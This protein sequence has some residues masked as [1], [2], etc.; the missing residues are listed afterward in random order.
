MTKLE[1]LR[2]CKTLGDFAS[3]IGYKPKSLSFILYKIPQQNKYNEFSIPKRNGDPRKIKSPIDELKL[4]QKHLANLLNECYGEINKNTYSLSHGFRKKH[5]ILSNASK[6]TNKR[7]VFNLD[8]EDFFPSINFGRVRGFLIKNKHFNL[9]E[10]VATV[11]AQ[12]A[13]H[14][15][16]LPQGSPCS[17]IIS[18]LIGHLL[19]IRMVNLAKKTKCTYSRYADD[20]TFSTNNK[21]FPEKIALMKNKNEW[22]IGQYLRKEITKLGFKVN[23]NKTSI[24]YKISRQTATGL[25]VNKKPNIKREYYKQARAMSYELFKT[26]NFYYGNKGQRIIGTLNQLVGTVNFIYKIKRQHDTDKTSK[27][28]F[29]PTAIT[30]L[31]RQLLFYK[32]FFANDKPLIICEGKTDIIYL[33]CA[34]SQLKN[35]NIDLDL[36]FLNMTKN[37]KD[38]LA[39]SQGVSGLVS[40]IEMY[41]YHMKIFKGKGKKNPVIILADNDSASK[42]I[43][44]KIKAVSR[45]FYN[46]VDNLY[47]TFV[48]D[49]K[50]KVIED[51]FYKPTLNIK[52]KGKKF[53]G[54]DKIDS[55]KE[56]GK[57]VFAEQVVKENQNTIN[58]KRFRYM[59]N[60]V[61]S[62]IMHHKSK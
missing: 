23:K 26:N 52:I 55:N 12:I 33:K 7:Y 32:Y 53:N 10:K 38:V 35:P 15:N 62:I 8:L 29:H 61:N 44:N 14:E 16:E 57:I 31:Y 45:P 30:K 3:L 22:V 42:D 37:F 25:V 21:D 1:S 48:S 27:R 5:S 4:V 36:R 43:R 39:I 34:L 2:K 59:F 24:Q 58:F 17:P 60:N 9:S 49:Q 11:I 54:A 47:I 6:H 41:E 50:G 46:Y 19:D 51:L 40:I 18:N 13:C 56:Y 20:L 28:R